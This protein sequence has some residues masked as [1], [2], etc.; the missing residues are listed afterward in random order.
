LQ[1]KMTL[2]LACELDIPSEQKA[3]F[4]SNTLKL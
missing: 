4:G 1:L 2:N 3:W